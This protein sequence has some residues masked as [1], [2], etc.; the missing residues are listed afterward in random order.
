M[1]FPPLTKN[2]PTPDHVKGRG[3]TNRSTRRLITMGPAAKVSST[4]NSILVAFNFLYASRT[5]SARSIPPYSKWTQVRQA[6]CCCDRATARRASR[7]LRCLWSC[8]RHPQFRAPRPPVK[9]YMD[10]I[11]KASKMARA[12]VFSTSKAMYLIVF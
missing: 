10:F 6:C 8:L 5:P 7:N 2:T 1:I 11:E 12:G 9:D 3:D 4:L